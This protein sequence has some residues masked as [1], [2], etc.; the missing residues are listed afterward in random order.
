MPINPTSSNI[1]A[2]IAQDQAGFQAFQRDMY[3][4]NIQDAKESLAM[5][6]AVENLNQAGKIANKLASVSTGFIT[7]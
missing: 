2:E 7:G 3:R 4:A 1:M 5:N 6:Q